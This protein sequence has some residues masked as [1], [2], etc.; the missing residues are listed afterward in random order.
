MSGY[1]ILGSELSEELELRGIITELDSGKFSMCMSGIGNARGDYERLIAALA[2][3]RDYAVQSGKGT[4]GESNGASEENNLGIKHGKEM[5]GVEAISVSPADAGNLFSLMNKERER[6]ETPRAWEWVPA[7]EAAGRVCAEDI[8]PYP[9]GVPLILA[10]EI[11]DCESLAFAT[12]YRGKG[13]KV[14][15]ITENMMVKVGK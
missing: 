12:E 7:S 8:T 2:D 15:G 1:G 13:G 5:T 3:I 14:F 10:G 9:P 11:M 6:V 4:C